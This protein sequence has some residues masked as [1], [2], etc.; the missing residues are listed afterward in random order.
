M[1]RCSASRRQVIHLHQIRTNP[2]CRLQLFEEQASFLLKCR[3][4][5]FERILASFHKQYRFE[6]SGA[7]SDALIKSAGRIL[8]RKPVPDIKAWAEGLIS[9]TK[10]PIPQVD[11]SVKRAGRKHMREVVVQVGQSFSSVTR[12]IGESGRSFIFSSPNDASSNVSR[13]SVSTAAYEEPKENPESA[14]TSVAAEDEGGSSALLA[15]LTTASTATTTT[16]R[17]HSKKRQARKL[18]P[19]L[20]EP[21][22]G[23]MEIALLLHLGKSVDF[24]E[25][26][27]LLHLSDS[28]KALYECAYDNLLTFKNNKKQVMCKKN[29]SVAL[30]CTMNLSLRGLEKY[31]DNEFISAASNAYRLVLPANRTRHILRP[32]AE[33]LELHDMMFLLKKVYVLKG[34]YAQ[35]EMRNE[36]APSLWEPV[37][38]VVEHLCKLVLRPSFGEMSSSEGDVVAEWKSIFNILLGAT[39]VYMKSG[40]CISESSK[41]VKAILDEEFDDFGRFGRKVDLS[42]L[43]YGQELANCEFKT[44]NTSDLDIELQNRKNIRLNRAIMESHKSSCDVRLDMLY[45]DIQGWN[46]SLFSLYRYEDIFV[47]KYLKTVNLPSSKSGMKKFLSGD[48]LEVILTFLVHLEKMGHSLKE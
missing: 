19:S 1:T 44:G 20:Q 21:W 5:P 45:M 38:N 22:K 24:P 46:G 7:L 36:T 27:D 39:D 47:S 34:E 28:R 11:N 10:N 31:F 2:P 16:T 13:P 14:I 43:A 32:L 8:N 25:M 18:G 17:L 9:K 33:V 30:S 4:L 12:A 3:N 26:P 29:A 6:T 40:E 23:L 37:L 15:S 35:M 48:D 41:E 42:F